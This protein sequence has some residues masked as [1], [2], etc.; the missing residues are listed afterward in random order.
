M[1][2]VLLTD[3]VFYGADSRDLDTGSVVYYLRDVNYG[4]MKRYVYQFIKPD[5]SQI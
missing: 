5:K 2:D 1:Q 3:L 4:Q